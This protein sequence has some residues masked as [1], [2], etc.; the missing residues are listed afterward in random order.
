MEPNYSPLNG[1][2]SCRLKTTLVSF[3]CCSNNGESFYLLPKY[4]PFIC[5]IL[6]GFFFPSSVPSLFL[7]FFSD[8]DFQVNMDLI[9]FMSLQRLQK[10]WLQ[11][12]KVVY[13]FKEHFKV[14]FLL[15]WSLVSIGQMPV[16]FL[17]HYFFH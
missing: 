12:S 9:I 16:F 6:P 13:M 11:L 5:H 2:A 7:A 3:F 4:F 1:N 14:L 10:K 15:L 17:R 8:T